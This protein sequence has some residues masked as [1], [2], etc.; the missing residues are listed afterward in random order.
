M[1]FAVV[2]HFINQ[3]VPV[4]WTS[5]VALILLLGGMQLILLGVLGEY[6]AR[7]YDETKQR[8]L[9]IVES[10]SDGQKES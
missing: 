5:T 3:R 7:V 9:Y 2:S 10:F 8:P 1:A 4:G 6:V